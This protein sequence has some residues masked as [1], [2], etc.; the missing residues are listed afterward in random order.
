M[1]AFTESAIFEDEVWGTQRA[2]SEELGRPVSLAESSRHLFGRG[3]RHV[4]QHPGSELRLT[5]TK[6]YYFWNRT[7]SSTN[8]NYYFAEDYSKL[9]R[10]LPF[11]MGVVAPLG[12]VGMILT[13]RRWRELAILYFVA[14]V[15]L[16]TALVFFVS[17][18]YRLPAAPIFSLFAASATI[19]L[20]KGAMA[21]LVPRFRGGRPRGLILSAILLVPLFVAVNI[22]DPLLRSQSLKRV[23]YLNFGTL[24]RNQGN[25]D[26][27]RDMLERSLAIDPR[28]GLAY[29]S[30]AEVY[31]KMGDE[32]EAARLAQLA[33][34]YRPA[35]EEADALDDFAARILTAGELYRSGQVE[36]ALRAFEQLLIDAEMHDDPKLTVSIRNNIGLCHYKLRDLD[37][38]VEIFTS[39]LREDPTYVKAH[40][41][42]GKVRAAEGKPAEA[43]RHYQDALTIDPENPIARRELE[44]LQAEP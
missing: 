22:R 41:N 3:A 27:A 42:L 32:F 7:E 40:N 37:K 8:L 6:L 5:M 16:V 4:W 24:Y 12:L 44:R 34:R 18:E 31:R 28:Y 1:P 43:L 36:L 21:L 9:L 10:A 33:H 25:Y 29:G 2:L 20:V 19:V 38:A 30:L 14:A 23:D 11:A 17:A 13:R 15:S 35:G 26:K 39:I